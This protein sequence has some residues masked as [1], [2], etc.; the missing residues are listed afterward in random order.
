MR[1]IRNLLFMGVLLVLAGGVQAGLLYTFDTDI[2]GFGGFDWVAG[3]AGWADGPVIQAQSAG[4]W[5]QAGGKEFTG[6][7]GGGVPSQQL[8]MQAIAN[9]G[10]GVIKYD[11]L[12]D[13]D[14]IPAATWIQMKMAFNSGAAGGG[15]TQIDDT[16]PLG[17]HNGP[18]DTALYAYEVEHTFAE[19]G[20]VQGNEW[21]QMIPIVN[22]GTAVK[23]YL[24]NVEITQ[25]PEPGTLALLGLGGLVA[26]WRRRR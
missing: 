18:T 13:A 8:E 25:I 26:L 6:D 16:I 4:G 14:S 12:I 9:S 7:P 1:I 10:L 17:W 2:E 23:F 22:S 19:A 15:W 5:W 3:P 21:F 24:D 20:Y 11:L